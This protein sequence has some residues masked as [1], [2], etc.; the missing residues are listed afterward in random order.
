MD[1][2]PL[3]RLPPELRNQIYTLAMALPKHPC[4]NGGEHRDPPLTQVCKEIRQDTL[5]MFYA[6]N[7]I[8][9]LVFWR[10]GTVQ[11]PRVARWLNEVDSVRCS[12][13][14]KIRICLNVDS[15]PPRHAENFE[16]G[17]VLTRKG[18]TSLQVQWIV[19]G[20]CE[21]L[22]AW[23]DFL[24]EHGHRCVMSISR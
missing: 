18:L 17:R 6:V 22:K 4:T 16:L 14:K 24:S 10:K 21:V 9:T 13:I 8:F 11:P 1:D 23:E 5:L 20:A 12:A 19:R 15:W 3:R 7:T 2:S